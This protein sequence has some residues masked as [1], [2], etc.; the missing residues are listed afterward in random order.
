VADALSLSFLIVRLS[1]S[2][3]VLSP[4]SV[5]RSQEI[6]ADRFPLVISRSQT[7]PADLEPNS[8]LVLTSQLSSEGFSPYLTAVGG[9]GVG[10]YLG[11]GDGQDLAR[12][13]E[14]KSTDD[15]EGWSRGLGAWGYA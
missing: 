3:F 14:E 1:L 4:L 7:C 2:F 13:L 8:L 12:G 5:G 6:L 10:L 9:A 11:G 15:L